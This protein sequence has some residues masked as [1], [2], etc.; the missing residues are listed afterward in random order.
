MIDRNQCLWVEK[1]RLKKPV[2]DVK[3]PRRGAL[4][5]VCAHRG[6]KHFKC[7]IKVTETFFLCQ[8]IDFFDQILVDKVSKKDCILKNPELLKRAY[9]LG[10]ALAA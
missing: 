2:S 10:M 1:Y 4:I 7:S 5:S 6:K 8:D 9:E 3:S